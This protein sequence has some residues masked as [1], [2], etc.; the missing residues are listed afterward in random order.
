MVPDND[1]ID[2]NEGLP[3]Q[4]WP[5]KAQIRSKIK[6]KAQ[7]S[8]GQNIRSD[9]KQAKNSQKQYSGYFLM[10]FWASRP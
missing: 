4:F 1:R 9:K 5:S 6:L 8:I 3:I 7:P 10:K 2:P